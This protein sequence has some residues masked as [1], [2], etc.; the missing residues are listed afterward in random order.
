MIDTGMGPLEH[1]IGENALLLAKKAMLKSIIREKI[2]EIEGLLRN[3]ENI[4][5]NDADTFHYVE[6]EKRLGDEANYTIASRMRMFTLKELEVQ[7]DRIKVG[8]K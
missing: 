5:V 4:T 8:E 2:F 3:F 6:G 1:S 7:L